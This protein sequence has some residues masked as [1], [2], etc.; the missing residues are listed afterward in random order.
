MGTGKTAE[1]HAERTTGI[2][3][4]DAA[5]ICGLSRYRTPMSVYLEKIQAAPPQEENAA[6]EWGT[7]LEPVV[8]DKFAELHPE[9]EVRHDD[10]LRRHPGR[11]WQI[12]H[13]DGWC[14][15]EADGVLAAG[16]EVKT[17]GREGRLHNW[18]DRETG[19]LRVPEEYVA[20]VHHYMMVTGLRRFYVAALFEGREYQEFEVPYDEELAA[21]ILQREVE[22]WGLVTSA[23]P[24]PIDASPAT[25]E[26]L[27]ILYRDVVD[28]HVELPADYADR[29]EE[30]A[31]LQRLVKAQQEEIALIDN[32]VRLALG[33]HEAGGVGPWRVTWKEQ[34]RKAYTVPAKTMRVL[35]YSQQE[36]AE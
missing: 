31:R 17:A 14:Y 29:L 32:E 20:Q 9:L 3:G 35:R 16:L 12:A 1:W 27:T 10:T 25:T 4:S 15:D 13:L 36:V 21:L 19:E 24:P 30:R 8:R 5:A 2:G 7:R 22:F 23:T 6:M 18:L 34:Q 33:P 26:V 28:E 11:P